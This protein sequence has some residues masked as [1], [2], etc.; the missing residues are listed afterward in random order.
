MI[1]LIGSQLVP[2]KPDNLVPVL[3]QYRYQ[4]KNHTTKNTTN[5]MIQ[6]RYL[7]S[8]ESTIQSHGL[9][10]LFPCVDRNDLYRNSSPTEPL[11]LVTT[12]VLQSTVV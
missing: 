12:P 9:I 3:V 10:Q 2:E 8:N 6:Y 1:S 4:A 11:S 7:C 5:C